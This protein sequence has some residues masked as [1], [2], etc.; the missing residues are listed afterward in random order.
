MWD[1]AKAHGMGL[2]SHDEIYKIGEIDIE[3]L[4]NFLG[5]KVYFFE[6]GK[7]TML[8]VVVYAFI[9][10]IIKPPIE[11]SL[12]SVV[13]SKKNIVAHCEHMHS[14]ITLLG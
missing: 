10:N 14:L 3:A 9:A 7:P 12:K 2:H 5:D 11:N 4:S 6:T 1:K 13:Q 8:D